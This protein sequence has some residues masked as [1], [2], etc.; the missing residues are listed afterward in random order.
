[1]GPRGMT[2]NIIAPGPIADTEGMKRLAKAEG[3][4]KAPSMIPTGRLGTVKEI[5]DATIYLFSEA[6]NYVN[7]ATLVGE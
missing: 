3:Y 4:G 5:A 7:G 6:G 1:M 2:S